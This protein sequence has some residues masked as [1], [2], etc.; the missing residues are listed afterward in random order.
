MVGQG[1]ALSP[2]TDI[3][4]DLDKMAMSV[5]VHTIQL[6]IHV[7]LTL[8]SSWI[9]VGPAAIK[10]LIERARKIRMV[11]IILCLVAAF[12]SN[13]SGDGNNNAR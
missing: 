6:M 7:R 5:K 12:P 9:G 10:A 3:R 2:S 13:T 4:C 11:N 1:S 8:P